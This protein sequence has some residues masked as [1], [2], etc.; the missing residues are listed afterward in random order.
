LNRSEN[1]TV[2]YIRVRVTNSGGNFPVE[3]ASVYITDY[4]TD[5]EEKGQLLYTLRTDSS[6]MTRTVTVPAVPASESREPGIPF[7]YTLYNIR[8]SR[9][10]YYTAES[11]GVPVF[12]GIV[13]VQPFRL[14]PLTE[15]D[16]AAIEGVDNVRGISPNISLT[17][18]VSTNGKGQEDVDVEG[19]S[20]TYFRENTEM[21]AAKAD[22]GTFPQS[23]TGNRI[24][25]V[26]F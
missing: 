24:S 26:R 17:A 23:T 4:N 15:T 5:D 20:G 2:G 22:F 11:I 18:N 7:P 25:P 14:Q 13:S 12:E 3:G 8:V 10:N 1:G 6:G 19:R 21:Y 9:E 16:L